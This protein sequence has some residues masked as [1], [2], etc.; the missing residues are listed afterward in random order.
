MGHEVVC[1]ECSAVIEDSAFD[2]GPQFSGTRE[3]IR[4]ESRVGAPTTI[5][6]HDRGFGSEIS[7][8]SDNNSLAMHRM[9]IQ[10]KRAKVESKRQRCRMF[11]LGEAK[12][13]VQALDGGDDVTDRACYIFRAAHDADLAKGRSLERL[14]TAAAH[15][16]LRENSIPR[17]ASDFDEVAR[18]D[19]E[20]V[21]ST[22][23]DI[24]RELDSI[25]VPPLTPADHVPALA[26]EFDM[27]NDD[28]RRALR[29]AIDAVE[30]GTAS[31]RSPSAFAAA[32]V[33]AVQ[34][35]LTQAAVADAAET[36]VNTLRTHWKVIRDF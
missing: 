6:R 16:A 7:Y 18:C 19:A 32:C 13:V 23:K 21:I 33:Y 4:K 24:Q 17:F 15:I 11:G 3:E 10:H 28:E 22:A 31:G 27:S 34:P 25:A 26:S 1:P 2:H 9:R 5:R 29:I 20:A 30:D 14:A 8:Q 35:E 12:R 36:S